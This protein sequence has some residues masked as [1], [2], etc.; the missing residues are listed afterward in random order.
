MWKFVCYENSGDA[1]WRQPRKRSQPWRLQY[2][3]NWGESSLTLRKEKI[4]DEPSKKA[5]YSSS[6][7]LNAFAFR[8]QKQHKQKID[9]NGTLD[10]Y[11]FVLSFA[12]A[13]TQ[14]LKKK[15]HNACPKYDNEL[16]KSVWNC[17]EVF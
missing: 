6:L 14:K 5:F 13:T 2:E 11:E 3:P 9:K 10:G 8:C 15:M 12:T 16:G 1:I 4:A 7:S 17:T